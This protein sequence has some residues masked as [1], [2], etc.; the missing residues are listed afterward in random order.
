MNTSRVSLRTVS[1]LALASMTALASHSVYAVEV[2]RARLLS[3][4]AQ[5]LVLS[6]ALRDWK[7]DETLSIQFPDREQWQQAGLTPPVALEG[8]QIE[9]QPGK[10]QI[11]LR[12]PQA[13]DAKV[14]DV[15]LDIQS[16]SGLQRHQV[17]VVNA[18][19]VAESLQLPSTTASTS[20]SYG[21]RSLTA[22][23]SS[24]D[25]YKVRTG[26]NLSSIAA[27]RT[28][29]G[30]ST[31]QYMAALLAANPDAF[32]H[33]NMNLLRAG[34]T[35]NAPTADQLQAYSD[36]EAR[37]LFAEQADWYAQY[38][39]GL[40]DHKSPAL[41]AEEA[42][43]GHARPQE[44]AAPTELPAKGDTLTLSTESWA[45]SVKQDQ[46]VATVQALRD[47]SENVEQLEE[48]VR[49]LSSALREQEA[50]AAAP[51]KSGA[52]T[53]EAGQRDMPDNTDGK[54]VQH[55]ASSSTTNEEA[56]QRSTS[57]TADAQGAEH[58]ALSTAGGEADKNDAAPAAGN[59][60]GQ[61]AQNTSTT[62]DTGST[63]SWIQE[64]LLIVMSALLALIVIITV[65]VLRR[66]NNSR[67]EVDS[68]APVTPEMVRE[69]L[70]KIN[71]DLDVPPSDEPT[72]S[73]RKP[74]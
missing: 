74:S 3:Q 48:N 70:E 27:K 54:Q 20:S 9:L 18:A 38:K 65:W 51:Q 4:P 32:Q 24:T 68:P 26:D 55:S 12:S 21:T 43:T 44:V 73:E 46:S 31:Y 15:L 47:A 2:G 30:V 71:L 62:T 14:I 49:Q 6:V 61:A 57:S 39:R 33:G 60:A 8:W 58:S 29:E 17:S 40:A 19:K 16:S 11:I 72:P 23:S 66:A 63:L 52:A 10:S 56:T 34:S 50:A 5:P 41:V 64:H 59:A 53:G 7:P 25:S 28:P 1:S 69:K 45:D 13:V 22:A 35:L 37:K 36:T 67:A 42:T